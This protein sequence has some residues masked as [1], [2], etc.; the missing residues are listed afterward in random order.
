M[1]RKERDDYINIS[2]L[3]VIIYLVF[4]I[5]SSIL[6]GSSSITPQMIEKIIFQGRGRKGKHL[7]LLDFAFGFRKAL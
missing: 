7:L 4:L 3:I 5:Y 6:G 1:E 2:F